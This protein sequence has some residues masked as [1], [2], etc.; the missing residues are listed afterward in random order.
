[1]SY[2]VFLFHPE[3]APK[4]FPKAVCIYLFGVC[5]PPPESKFHESQDVLSFVHCFIHI[6]LNSARQS[7]A[8]EI[9]VA[10]KR[11]NC[12]MWSEGWEYKAVEEGGK[13]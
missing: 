5:L 1:M 2:D 13:H 3:W 12:W 11:I 8:Q 9:L 4:S 7:G 10:Q 6:S